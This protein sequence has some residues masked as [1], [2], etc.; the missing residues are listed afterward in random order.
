MTNDKQVTGTGRQ[1]RHLV[2]VY[3]TDAQYVWLCARASSASCAIELQA[4]ADI[5]DANRREIDRLLDE[6]VDRMRVE[7]ATAKSRCPNCDTPWNLRIVCMY[8]DMS[9]P[10]AE[11]LDGSRT[12]PRGTT[13]PVRRP[14]L[15]DIAR[16]VG[17]TPPSE[18]TE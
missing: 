4:L 11:W 16:R 15:R 5:E 10:A 9:A 13:G 8:C 14:I 2:H 7:E 12:P 3:L 6:H 1:R 18:D 17:E